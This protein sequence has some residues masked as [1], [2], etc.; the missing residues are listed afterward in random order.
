ELTS[1]MVLPVGSVQEARWLAVH[2]LRGLD[3]FLVPVAPVPARAGWVAPIGRLTMAA[4]HDGALV[5]SR[6]GWLTRRLSAVP[7]RRVQSLRLFQGPL[8]RRL[9]LATLYVDSPPGPVQVTWEL[10]EAGGL[11]GQLA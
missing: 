5:V 6:R 11:R 10:R 2:V 8:L 1:S 7:H 4:G 9:R 3:P